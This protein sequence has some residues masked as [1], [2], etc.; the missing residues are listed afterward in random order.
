MEPTPDKHINKVQLEQQKIHEGVNGSFHETTEYVPSVGSSEF[1][2][3]ETSSPIAFGLLTFP[4]ILDS[5][6]T[7]LFVEDQE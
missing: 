7:W 6:S 4:C 1:T 5:C 3:P 2:L